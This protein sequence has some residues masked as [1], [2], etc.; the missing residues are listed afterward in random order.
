MYTE[1]DVKNGFNP[2]SVRR[3][4]RLERIGMVCGFVGIVTLMV[5]LTIGGFLD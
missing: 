1:Q 5:L 3:R 4:E 2:K